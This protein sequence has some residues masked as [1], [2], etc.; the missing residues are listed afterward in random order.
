MNNMQKNEMKWSRLNDNQLK[1]CD[2]SFKYPPIRSRLIQKTALFPPKTESLVIGAT[3]NECTTQL[4][5]SVIIK[6]PAH[7]VIVLRLITKN[8]LQ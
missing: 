8:Y 4:T 5:Q 3:D 6:H 7:C 1:S 2:S